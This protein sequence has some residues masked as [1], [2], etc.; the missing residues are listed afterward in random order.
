MTV[1]H[2]AVCKHSHHTLCIANNYNCAGHSKP[3]PGL[4]GSCQSQASGSHSCIGVVLGASG[5]SPASTT[6]ALVLRQ[7]V[8]CTAF[9]VLGCPSRPTKALP[10]LCPSPSPP[11]PHTHEHICPTPVHTLY[12]QCTPLC[13][14]PVHTPCHLTG[15]TVICALSLR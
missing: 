1:I 7:Q 9:D 6:F 5:D 8:H 2:D 15:C 14:T 3:L 12:L 13:P 4:L 11:P 10:L